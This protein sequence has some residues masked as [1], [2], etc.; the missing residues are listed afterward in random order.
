MTPYAVD[1]N[2]VSEVLLGG[3]RA[4][5]AVL[6]LEA[7]LD[8]GV[9]ASAWVAAEIL[10]VAPEHSDAASVLHEMGI[11]ADY[12]VT[13]TLLGRAAVGWRSYL[14]RRR[15]YQDTFSC[16]LCGAQQAVALCTGC[17]HRIRGPRRIL[18]DFLIGAHAVERAQG[19]ITWDRGVYAAY[20]PTLEIVNPSGVP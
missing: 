3:P 17:G 12:E 7:A 15:R 13:D 4:S 19:L 10:A 11:A 1:S 18:A 6:A 2:V 20:F 16:P 14:D 8:V 5:E 9:V